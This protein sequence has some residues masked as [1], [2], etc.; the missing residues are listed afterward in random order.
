LAQLVAHAC[1]GGT[2]E[3]PWVEVHPESLR[4]YLEEEMIIRYPQ[5]DWNRENGARINASFEA[6]SLAL[7]DMAN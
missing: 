7:E 3:I 1:G 4:N 2:V 5:A 6:P